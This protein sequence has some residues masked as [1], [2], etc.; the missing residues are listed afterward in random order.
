MTPVVCND[1][2]QPTFAFDVSPTDVKN[3]LDKQQQL[4]EF[5]MTCAV[6]AAKLSKAQRK[7]V[8]AVLTKNGRII[9]TGYNG[10]PT[11]FDNCCEYVTKDGSLKT[12]PTVIHAEMNAILFCAKYGIP[13]EDTVLYI[14][15]SPCNNCVTSIIQSGIKHVYYLEE[16]RDTSSVDF[17]RQ[18]GI[19]VDQIKL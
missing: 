5:F 2:S 3:I 12:K 13:T 19:P 15:L 9:S 11:G 7:K 14:T 18:V 10:Q 16:Y 8:G 6:A 4:H 1:Y 17:L